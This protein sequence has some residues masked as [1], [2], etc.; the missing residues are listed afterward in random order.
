M[1]RTMMSHADLLLANHMRVEHGMSLK[2]IA[3]R[4]DVTY[5]TVKVTYRDEIEPGW[6][7]HG[8]K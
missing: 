6:D 1:A 2:E 4:F 5:Y 8:S 7:N 3:D